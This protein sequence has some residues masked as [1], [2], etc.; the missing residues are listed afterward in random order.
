MM[1]PPGWDEANKDRRKHIYNSRLQKAKQLNDKIR[2]WIQFVESDHS[3]NK[4][5]KTRIKS[6]LLKNLM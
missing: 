6:E 1:I 2:K 4:Q 3:L 5:Q